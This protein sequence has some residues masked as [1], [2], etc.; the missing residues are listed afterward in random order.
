MGKLVRVDGLDIT[1]NRVLHLDPV[2]RVFERDPLHSVLILSNHQWSCGRDGARSGIGVYSR[3]CAG[4]C[5]ERRVAV[6][7]GVRLGKGL[8]LLGFLEL[9]WGLRRHFY[10]RAVRHGLLRV[11]SLVLVRVLMLVV[12]LVLVLMLVLMRVLV[13]VRG[14][15]VVGC[16]LRHHHR[17]LRCHG[18]VRLMA[19]GRVLSVRRLRLLASDGLV[20]LL[21]WRVVHGLLKR[22]RRRLAIDPTML[23]MV[24]LCGRCHGCW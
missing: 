13:L 15:G 8:C 2:A 1:T 5:R 18:L 23:M 19:N 17:R 20:L 22:L 24:M 14:K 12:V 21:L 4:G 7:S 10:A 6:L 3:G 16:R 9:Y 11:V